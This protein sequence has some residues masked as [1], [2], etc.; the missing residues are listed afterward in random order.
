MFCDS[1]D[2]LL[3]EGVGE[4]ALGGLGGA[5]AGLELVAE[6]HQLVD[7]G[8]DAVLFGEWR[9][10]NGDGPDLSNTQVVKTASSYRQSLHFVDSRR[11][12]QKFRDKNFI[13]LN[14][15]PNPD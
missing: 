1:A 10:W 3:D 13:S 12:I 15:R 5:E 14:D 2:S 4:V 7:F 11:R 6:G 9:K 8:D